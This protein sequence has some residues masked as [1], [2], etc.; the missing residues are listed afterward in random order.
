MK[1]N[2][3]G[4]GGI[5]AMGKQVRW[6]RCFQSS[7]TF[8]VILLGESEMGDDPSPTTA[9]HLTMKVQGLSLCLAGC[10]CTTYI[11]I[12]G[13]HFTQPGQGRSLEKELEI[14]HFA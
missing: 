8:G 7:R 9:Q 2:F 13:G 12:L 11:Y 4:G 3:F 10:S 5:E 6:V 1:Y 14:Q